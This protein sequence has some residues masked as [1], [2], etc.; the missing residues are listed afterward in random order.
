MTNSL[1]L[2]LWVKTIETI[3]YSTFIDTGDS[4]WLGTYHTTRRLRADLNI[5]V[6][7]DLIVPEG[8]IM[9]LWRWYHVVST[10]DGTTMKLYQDREEIASQPRTG[11]LNPR[12]EN[13]IIGADPGLNYF[14]GNIRDVMLFN[15][16]LLP[17]EINNIYRTQK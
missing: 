12:T 7:D 9:E 11:I 6:W 2:S 1:S 16:A 5:G 8:Y 3:S 14:Y 10:W 13:F 17:E 4:Y 15:R